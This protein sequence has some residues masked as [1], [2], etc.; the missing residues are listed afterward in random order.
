MANEGELACA[1]IERAWLDAQSEQPGIAHPARA[2]LLAGADG[3]LDELKMYHVT[4][5]VRKLD[6]LP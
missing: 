3:W 2:W 6:P 4:R 5:Q 1:M